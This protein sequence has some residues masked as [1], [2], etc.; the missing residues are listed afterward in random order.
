LL[1]WLRSPI[2]YLEQ[3][4]TAEHMRSLSA[5]YFNPRSCLHHYL[6]MASGNFREY[7]KDDYV[8]VKKYFYVL[9]PVLAC[10]WIMKT[11]L[12][13]VRSTNFLGSGLY[14]FTLYIGDS[15]HVVFGLFAY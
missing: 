10:Q 8:P 5:E 9:R 12:L 14:C 15:Q 2:I 6:H 1:E 4:N 7:L 13:G 11:K 3:F